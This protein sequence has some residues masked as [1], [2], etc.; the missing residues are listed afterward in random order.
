MSG[1]LK[2]LGKKSYCPWKAD[3]LARVR[4]DE[5]EQRERQ[6]QE[7]EREETAV[8]EKRWDTLGQQSS[9]R[10]QSHVNLF[11]KEEQDAVLLKTA[12]EK[13]QKKTRGDRG[14]SDEVPFYLKK[15]P[16]ASGERDDKLEYQERKRRK[17]LD[18]MSR[19]HPDQ[20]ER[21]AEES[22]CSDQGHRK[23][24]GRRRQTKRSS[25]SDNNSSG[26]EE[27]DS[28]KSRRGKRRRRKH[29]KKRKDKKRERQSTSSTW[30]QE[31]RQKRI[32]RERQEK[33][34]QLQLIGGK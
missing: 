15:E 4:R 1:R 11:E 31:L 7:Q 34:R 33:E 17:K 27:D 24:Q 2:I 20:Y 25:S 12:P 28:N 5:K 22:I 14:V 26:D 13:S 8:R 10:A 9:A 23:K 16:F 3:N 29:E 18:P 21:K 6:Q 30:M 32:E 19:Y